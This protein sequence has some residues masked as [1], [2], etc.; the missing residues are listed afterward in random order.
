MNFDEE[1]WL[2]NSQVNF[3]FAE[4]VHSHITPGSM[5]WV[6]DYHLM[7][8][9]MILRGLVDGSSAGESQNWI[10]SQRV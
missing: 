3:R 4:T 2:M 7:L 5:V 6:Q 8:L 10:K 1:N 9:P